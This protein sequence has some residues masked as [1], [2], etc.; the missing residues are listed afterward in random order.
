MTINSVNMASFLQSMKQF[1]TVNLF[2]FFQSFCCISH[3]GDFC[4][5]LSASAIGGQ[6]G[7]LSNQLLSVYGSYL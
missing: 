2:Y 6:A 7:R 1:L 5:F 4:N 3:L